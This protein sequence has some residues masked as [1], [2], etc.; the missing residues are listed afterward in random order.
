MPSRAYLVSLGERVA[1]VAASAGLSYTVKSLEG[2]NGA[3]V[4]I[5][6]VGCT[7]LIGIL[8]RFVGDPDSAGLK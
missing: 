4:P 1:A 8:A 5:L 6:T 2:M 3:W 7:A